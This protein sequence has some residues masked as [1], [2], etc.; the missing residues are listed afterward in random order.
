MLSPQAEKALVQVELQFDVVSAALI[1]GEPA[2]LESA[3]AGLRQVAID[4]SGLLQGLAPAELAGKNL[5]LRLKKLAEGMAMQR[6]SLIRRTVAVERTLHAI[7]PATRN[8]TYTQTSGPYGSSGR[9]TGA[10]KLLLA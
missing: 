7:M 2:A 10:F 9:P 8:A 4:F 6:E 1:S 3:S 5:K